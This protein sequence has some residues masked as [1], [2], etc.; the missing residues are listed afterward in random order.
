M[1]ELIIGGETF[2]VLV[3]GAD[4][5]PVLM[6]SNSLGTNL[7]MW[8]KQMGALTRHFRVVRYDSRGHGGSVVTEGPYSIAELGR[9]AIAIMDALGLEKVHWLG[10]S[11]GGMVGQWLLTHEPHRIGHAVL[12]N[13][14][15][16]MAGSDIWND[17]IRI[18]L[19][20]GMAAL[21]PTVME[22]W[23]T[24][25]FR[26]DHSDEVEKIRA[27][28]EATS[29]IGYAACC[30]AIRDMD[31]LAAL[32]SV[33]S[34][35]LV[36]VGKQDPATPPGMGALIASAIPGAQIVTLDVAH[37]SNIE[38]PAGFNHAVLEFL[39]THEAAPHVALHDGDAH[40]AAPEPAE[41]EPAAPEPAE[42][43]APKKP[44]R[45]PAPRKAPEPAAAE[46]EPQVAMSDELPAPAPEPEVAEKPAAAPS[47]AR[48][49]P[50]KK[51][52]A[53]KTAAKKAARKAPARGAAKKAPAKKTPAKKSSA[54]KAVAKKAATKKTA[55]KSAA[56]K[57]ATRKAVVKRTPAK[58]IAAKKTAG[59]KT[60]VKKKV[61]RKT[62]IKKG[63]VK[64]SAIKRTPVKKIAGKKAVIK[65]TAA[66]KAS[67]RSVSRRA[68]ARKT[69]WRGRRR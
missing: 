45:K 1:A 14:S 34:P 60:A 62:A 67:K 20:E 9:D 10:L 15:A 22:R 61:T 65:K 23:F 21:A 69:A 52:A 2:N 11:K 19:E 29:P 46:A 41:S 59:R 8:D 5:A 32:P 47:T 4:G 18:A 36:I 3:E 43:A 68:P 31:Q 54:R 56:R 35:V 17:R 39:G 13:T 58:K 27:V 48:R 24:K 38:D 51:A 57:A 50:V 12:A 33:T 55:R 64:K 66:K 40:H 30:G 37:L 7:H 28:L 25:S 6:L 49:R 16:V 26:E 44:R 63:A 42:P 53:K